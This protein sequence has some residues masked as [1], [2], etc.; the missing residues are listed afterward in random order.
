[1]SF[2]KSSQLL[3][4][5]L[6][7]VGFMPCFAQQA[8][9]KVIVKPPEA[10]IFLDGVAIG[11]DHQRLT[12]SPGKHTIGVYNYGF[13]PD[14]KEI[15]VT[16]GMNDRLEISLEP[17]GRGEVSGPWGVLQVEGAKNAAV[18]LNGKTPEFFVGH[19][20]MENHHIWWKQQL[21]LPVGTFNVT[22]TE[23]GKELFAEPVTINPNERTIIYV[24]Q[25]GRQVVKSWSEGTHMSAQPRFKAGLTTATVA[26]APVGGSMAA[27]PTAINCNDTVT[28][29]WKTDETLHAYLTAEPYM[30]PDSRWDLKAKIDPPSATTE[31]VPL[32]GSKDFQPKITTKYSLRSPGP[33]GVVLQSVIVPV[34]P[35]VHTWLRS[36]DDP[37]HYVRI[38]DKTMTQDSTT[39][40]WIV[41][42]ADAIT[43]D[44]IGNVTAV[45]AKQTL[46]ERTFSPAPKSTETGPV[47]EKQVY[48]L[49]ASNVC[50]GSDTATTAVHLVGDIEP[51]IASVFFPTAF[52]KD[53][54]HTIGLL[55]SQQMQL[56]PIATAFKLYAEHELNAKLVVTGYADSR[57]SKGS[58][59]KL[60][61]RRAEKVRGFLL[62]MG[63]PYDKIQVEWRGEQES[64]DA[65]AVKELEAKNPTP[66]DAERAA[67]ERDTELA[68]NR[69]VDVAIM[70]AAIESAKFYPHAADGS[71]VMWH[72]RVEK[73]QVIEAK[74]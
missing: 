47:D 38:G 72:R 20:D 62:D 22:V 3:A 73:T 59:M 52:P 37:V 8:Q 15:N 63:V 68:Y 48:K 26:V 28:I 53:E 23:Q 49:T 21:I 56:V 67:A 64:L 41:D 10:Q 70:P 7:I 13:K 43:I 34:N 6:V 14:I 50:G 58:N 51:S 32:T 17:D 40:N 66:A 2:T 44:E 11:R 1:M 35:V 57:D 5:A 39:L 46:G 45:P 54:H 27:N 4:A 36:K 74:Q 31:E 42:N 16:D 9:I 12:M 24:D 65:N 71:N 18:L 19:G 25:G 30:L 60:S 33:G 55:H 61:Q 29:S 69:R